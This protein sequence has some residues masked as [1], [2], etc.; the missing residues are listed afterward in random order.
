M[1]Q[2]VFSII[3]LSKKGTKSKI[4]SLPNMTNTF[5]ANC[6]FNALVSSKSTNLQYYHNSTHLNNEFHI[7][8]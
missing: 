2:H 5:V 1:G 8:S 6:N 7:E 3:E 4:I